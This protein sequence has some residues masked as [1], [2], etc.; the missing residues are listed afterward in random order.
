MFIIKGP[1]RDELLAYYR[2]DPGPEA[3][4]ERWLEVTLCATRDGQG[5]VHKTCMTIQEPEQAW[6]MGG[7]VRLVGSFSPVRAPRCPCSYRLA[8]RRDFRCT[9]DPLT[10]MGPVAERPTPAFGW[11]YWRTVWAGRLQRLW[12]RI[13]RRHDRK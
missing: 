6:A 12:R 13:A 9:Y 3:G 11:V 10:R 7:N 4:A 1:T 5:P 2:Q 8:R